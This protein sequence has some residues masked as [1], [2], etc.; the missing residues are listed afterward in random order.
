MRMRT[1][2]I[3]KLKRLLAAS[4]RNENI[5]KI[6]QLSVTDWLLFDLVLVHE[7]VDVIGLVIETIIPFPS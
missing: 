3:K 1:L 6:A 5:S 7:D 2:T 4:D